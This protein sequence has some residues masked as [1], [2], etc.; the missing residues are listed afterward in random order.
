MAKS[1]ITAAL[2]TLTLLFSL[3]SVISPHP[4]MA[5]PDEVKWSKVNIPTQG[6]SGKWVL[7]AGSDVRHLTL[8]ADGTIYGYTTPSETSYTLFKSKDGG[9]GWSYTGNVQDAMVDI[10]ATADDANLVYY[11]TATGVYKS[12]DAG[13]SFAPLPPNAGGAGGN[14]IEITSLAVAKVGNSRIV[15]VGTR[16]TDSSQYGGVYTLNESEPVPRWQDTDIGSYDVVALAFSPHF[17]TDQQLVAVVTDETDT[18]VTTRTSSGEW[19]KLLGNAIIKSVSARAATI[20]FPEGYE[21]TTEGQSLF[22]GLDTGSEHGD[23][24][25]VAGRWWPDSSIATDLNI[26]VA[27]NLGNVDVTGLAVSG[28][29]ADAYLLAGAANS[30][31]V[32]ISADGGLTWKRSTKEPTGQSWTYMVMAPDFA[33]SRRAYAATSGT[34]SAFSYSADGGL[35]WNQT[36][37]IDT[38]ITSSGLIDLAVSPN[39][40]QDNTLFLLTWGGEHSL[41]RTLDGG[42]RWE[43]VFDSTRPDIDTI[44]LVKLSPQYGSG[45]QVIF[46]AGTWGGGAAIWQSADNGQSFIPRGVPRTI[47]AWAVTD[48]NSLWLGSY[49][50]TNGLIYHM[51]NGAVFYSSEVAVGQQPLKSIVLSP[52][53]E[54]DGTILVGNTYGWVYWSSDNGTSF[55][56]LGQQLPLSGTGVGQVTLAFDPE[57][58]SNKTVYAATDAEST[59]ASKERIFRFI[60]GK[61]E[62]WESLDS[63]LPVGSIVNQ[64]AAS[65]DG[66][67]YAASSQAVDNAT[68]KGG[69]ERSLNPA[70]ALGATFETVIRGLSDNTTLT[71]LWVVGNQLWSLDTTHTRLMTYL[72]TLTSPVM[73]TSPSDK[74]A[75]VETSN[76]RLDWT[77]LKGTTKYQWQIDYDNDFSTVPSG[78]EGNTE[79]TSVRLPALEMGTTYYWRVRAT[80]PVLSPWSAKWSFTTSL[81]KAVV[82]PELKTPEA[83]ATGV[84]LRPIFQWSAIAGAERY[85]LVVSTE[86]SLANPVIAKTGDAAVPATAW[87]IDVSLDYNTTYY[88]KVRAAGSGSYSAWSAVSA[89]TTEVAPSPTQSPPAVPLTT[90][91]S[92]I[93]EASPTGVPTWAL[94][95]IG[96]G[97]LIVILLVVILLMLVV[98]RRAGQP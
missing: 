80:E 90:S 33:T 6:T 62:A 77:S 58:S 63:T 52:D 54:T 74:E 97:T 83:G 19:G 15:A 36:G 26:G 91:T 84:P 29:G 7:A 78:F 85:E 93:Q 39:Y 69:M 55:E 28:Q 89:F 68:K 30:A 4:V 64:L 40:S 24:Y 3:I 2:L 76:V 49:N 53:Y 17:L 44:S 82:A 32:Y 47:D 21:A 65:A 98:R 10:A 88:W 18:I 75:G 31:Q 46:L 59:S 60:I 20:A 43:R 71:G 41:W 25:R 22:V 86:A 38:Q 16:D 96:L 48:N 5:T 72:D 51:A 92:T 14:N 27:Y 11:A 57:F 94:Y 67:L 87:Q 9:Y 13:A 79:E 56:S 50:G 12:S 37:L 34:E 35:T 81:G 95:L 73:L 61:S 42:G 1:Q 70:Y 66:L 45:S 23:V 8:A